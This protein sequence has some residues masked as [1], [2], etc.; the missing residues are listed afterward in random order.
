MGTTLRWAG[1]AVALLLA[2]VLVVLAVV[3]GRVWWFAR[4]DD[5]G[6]ADV[7]VVLGAAQFD[8]RP[9]A[10]FEARLRHAQSLYLDGVAPVVITTG[11]GQP[12]DR[13]TEADAGAHWLT[14]HGL[15]GEAV[16]AVPEGGS[17]LASL[18]AVG[19]RA[20]EQSWQTAVLVTDPW[21]ALRTESMA[22]DLGL[23]AT[24]SPTRQGP[25]VRDRSTQAR[26]VGRETL[27]YLYWRVLGDRD[28]TGPRAV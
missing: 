9:S 25:T 21:H 18:Q 6:A 7:L 16:V 24:S 14:D 1:R 3:A 22:T 23:D 19:V 10:V 26:Y 28:A 15:P 4:Q 13:T 5:R 11:G 8:G 12:G 20:Q 2:A 27:A 17:T